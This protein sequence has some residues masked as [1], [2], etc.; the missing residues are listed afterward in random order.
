M[1]MSVYSCVELDMDVCVDVC[2]WVNVCSDNLEVQSK[3]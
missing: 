2:I 1:K 3:G